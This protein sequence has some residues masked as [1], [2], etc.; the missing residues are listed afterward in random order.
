MPE[1]LQNHT[2]TF[3]CQGSRHAVEALA[4]PDLTAADV[5]RGFDAYTRPHGWATVAARPA[6]EADVAAW[7]AE[8]GWGAVVEGTAPVEI[9]RGAVPDEAVVAWLV[10][11]EPVRPPRPRHQRRAHGR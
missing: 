11:L 5:V 6:P 2:C 8:I 9:R 7:A 10:F 3:F 1:P 4:K